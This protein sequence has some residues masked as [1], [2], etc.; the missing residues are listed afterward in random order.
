MFAIL[1]KT[2]VLCTKSNIKLDHI[3]IDFLQPLQLQH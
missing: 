2:Y 3:L 1:V